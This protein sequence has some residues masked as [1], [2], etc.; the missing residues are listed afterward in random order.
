MRGSAAVEFAGEIWGSERRGFLC[1]RGP[2]GSG[3]AFPLLVDCGCAGTGAG[4]AEWKFWRVGRWGC[5][6]VLLWCR[7][8]DWMA[9]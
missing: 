7:P 3:L 1:A 5:A 6:L 9:S 8:V 4:A 2:V